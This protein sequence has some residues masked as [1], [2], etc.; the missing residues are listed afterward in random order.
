[1]LTQEKKN[2]LCLFACFFVSFGLRTAYQFGFGTYANWICKMYTR[3]M[4]YDASYI[5][6]DLTSIGAILFLHFKNFRIDR[7]AAAK[8]EQDENQNLLYE[9]DR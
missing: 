9:S 7:S 5:L 1:M 6:F 3:W 8:A 2:L 4:L